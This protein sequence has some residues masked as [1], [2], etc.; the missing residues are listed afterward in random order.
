VVT[1]TAHSAR[2]WETGEFHEI[3]RVETDA[4]TAEVPVRLVVL[5]PRPTFLQVSAWYV[6]LFVG[7]LVPSLVVAISGTV[8][9]TTLV[10]SA[11][12]A[13]GLLAV[14]LLLI[15]VAAD[16]GVGERVACG[17][18]TAVMCFVLGVSVAAGP[19]N[20]M[21]ASGGPRAALAGA[22]IGVVLVLQLLS[23]TRWKF[24]AAAMGLLSM[25]IGVIFSHLL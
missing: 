13:S 12:V 1:L 3:V 4:G 11:A 7:A 15:A 22:A 6:P 18:L 20:S 10:P 2:S 23:Y 17:I 5:K 9:A 8:K 16:A 19:H 21:L 24:W 25:A 14:M